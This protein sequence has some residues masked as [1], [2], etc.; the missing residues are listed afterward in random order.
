M[1]KGKFTRKR[2]V[3][4]ASVLLV[5]ILLEAYAHT[6]VQPGSFNTIPQN[7]A[8]LFSNISDTGNCTFMQG[9]SLWL[10]KW[11]IG[12]TSTFT[13]VT[14]AIFK[15]SENCSLL[16]PATGIIISNLQI[17][18]DSGV[19]SLFKTYGTTNYG[20]DRV[21]LRDVLIFPSNGTY[22]FTYNLNIKF[23]QNSILGLIPNGET[24]IPLNIQYTTTV[25]D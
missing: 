5:L 15:I 2:A 4:V 24:T 10:V 25:R 7:E 18:Y 23:Y 20:S 9:N 6:Y 16:N 14:I 8:I 21:D 1:D 22:N 19:L 17:D 12:N 3:L 13:P 11:Y